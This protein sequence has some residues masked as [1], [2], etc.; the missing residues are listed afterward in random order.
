[1]IFAAAKGGFYPTCDGLT[2]DDHV[3][4]QNRQNEGPDAEGGREAPGQ[5][6]SEP[7]ECSDS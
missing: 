3:A 6:K 7:R 4:D 2:G 5:Q 1:M